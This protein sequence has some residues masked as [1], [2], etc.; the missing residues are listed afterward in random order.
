M[1]RDEYGNPLEYEHAEVW[2][3]TPEGVQMIAPINNAM[4][5]GINYR[6]HVPLNS[7]V[8]TKL[9]SATALQPSHPFQ[10][11]VRLDDVFYLPIEMNGNLFQLGEPAGVTRLNLTLG[12]DLD[13]DGL[14]DAWERML[15]AARLDMSSDLS[16]VSPDADA[17]QDGLSN[18][19]EYLSG[20][21]AFDP[22][23]G[24]ELKL[25]LDDPNPPVVEFMAIKGRT[26]S[27]MA[28]HDFEAWT[29]LEFS[30]EG[31]DTTI[32]SEH[33]LADD[34]RRVRA[35]ILKQDSLANYQFFKLM[36]Q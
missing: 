17:D 5:P 27:V 21:Y 15:L 23:N 25:I 6:F 7:G 3:E 31:E 13:G 29:P 8:A 11:R 4:H 22:E 34:V 32:S 1:V 28:S 10:I 20:T 16:A 12:E 2:L 26:Y 35:T 14:P 36:V 33:Y 18:L 19:Q 24:F 9:P 30:V